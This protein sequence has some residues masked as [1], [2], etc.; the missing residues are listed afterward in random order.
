MYAT[1]LDNS[2]E[3]HEDNRVVGTEHLRAPGGI[4]K[5]YAGFWLHR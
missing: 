3:R 5:A 2:Y 4:Q 1:V